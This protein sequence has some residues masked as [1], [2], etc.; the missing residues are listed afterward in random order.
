MLKIIKKLGLVKNSDLKYNQ[1]KVLF[2]SSRAD[3]GGGPKHLYLLLKHF[4]STIQ[5]WVAIPNEKPYWDLVTILPIVKEV[6]AIPHRRFSLRSLILLRSVIVNNGVNL[7][8]SHGKGAGLFGRVLS[9]ITGINCI[10]TF[11]GLHI[12]E[13]N[14][15]FRTIYLGLERIMAK[16]TAAF[17][18]VSDGERKLI[19]RLKITKIDRVYL[20][21]NGVETPLN[22]VL[23]PVQS[24]DRLNVLMISRFD[25]AKNTELVIPIM[26]HLAAKSLLNRF[27][28]QII[29]S[30]IGMLAVKE[31]IASNN[32]KDSVRF[33]G[34]VQDISELFLTGYCYLSTSRW[35][36][37]PLALLEAQSFGIPVIATDVV[38][39]NDVIE[40]G[41]NGFLY[42]IDKP[43]LAASYLLE[44]YKDKK[45]WLELSQHI[46]T[47][48]NPKY[49]VENMTKSTERLYTALLS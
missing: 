16:F 48:Y 7:I 39:N 24:R 2:I 38:G 20:I 4:S 32:Y 12:G 34:D 28:F 43:E 18:S 49:R 21:E 23:Y 47:N 11:H 14:I 9:M 15:I 46:L 5:A 42:N 36:G 17:I 6:I 31:L 3:H 45:L 8:H 10:H 25:Y 1:I 26:K 22:K 30:G 33:H 40:Q 37:L 29:G 27:T 35:E 19:E 13:Y 44:M 41:K